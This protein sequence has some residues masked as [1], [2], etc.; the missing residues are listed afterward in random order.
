[1]FVGIIETGG[2]SLIFD[3]VIR[4]NR[5]IK[6][7][8]VALEV[9]RRR[10]DWGCFGLTWV[11]KSVY[12]SYTFNANIDTGSSDKNREITKDL[13]NGAYKSITTHVATV[14]NHEYG[15]SYNQHD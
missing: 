5:W 13:L 15:L 14:T 12:T 3:G 2:Y 10:K 8:E 11:R 7:L 1:M 4:R 6:A 9:E